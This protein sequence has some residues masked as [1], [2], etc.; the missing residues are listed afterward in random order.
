MG[1]GK[2]M[3]YDSSG[4]KIDKSK[5]DWQVSAVQAFWDKIEADKTE[6]QSLYDAVNEGAIKL[7]NLLEE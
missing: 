2:Y 3:E 4:N 6:M 7:E 1:F 5:D